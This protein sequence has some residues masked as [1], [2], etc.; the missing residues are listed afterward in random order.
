MEDSV[1]TIVT[2]GSGL[3]AA[4]SPLLHADDLAALRGDGVFET[5]LVRDGAACLLDAHLA[6]LARSAE[7]MDLPAPNLTTG[8]APSTRRCS[9]GPERARA[10]CE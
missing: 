10:R 6:R 8:A 2:V 4:G 7:L 1:V 3:A 5:L 9:S